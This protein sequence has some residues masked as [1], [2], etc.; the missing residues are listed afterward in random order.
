MN[1]IE[2]MIAEM[3]HE[4]SFTRKMLERIPEA[5]LGWRPHEKS[6]T[7]G[8]LASHLADL[9]GWTLPTLNQ[10]E[11]SFDPAT[12]K[13]WLAKSTA[14]LVQKHDETIAAA[15]KAMEG[16][17]NDK[18]IAP[19]SLKMAGQTM[20]TLPR[21][22]VLRGMI[23]NH[24]IHHRAQLGV[25]LRLKDVPIPAIYGPSADEQA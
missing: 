12:Y 19:W 24:L 13:P 4:A 9:P 3:K 23:M 5:E 1:F 16:Y 20:F 15:L 17:P 25:Y 2:P 7:L 14:E 8:H 18:L 10:D 22:A 21:A 6:F 11:L